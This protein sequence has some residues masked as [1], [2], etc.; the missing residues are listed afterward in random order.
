MKGFPE[1][2]VGCAWMSSRKRGLGLFPFSF[3]LSVLEA[4]VF[5]GFVCVVRRLGLSKLESARG[6][7][8]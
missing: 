4:S 8:L 7:I 1:W 3:G 2:F 6:V 5:K